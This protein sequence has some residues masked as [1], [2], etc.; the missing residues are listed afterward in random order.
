LAPENSTPS[1]NDPKEVEI[2][3]L[4]TTQQN[5]QQTPNIELNPKTNQKAE[6]VH[7]QKPTTTNRTKTK[8]T[9]YY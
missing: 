6:V 9:P 5:L 3:Q 7:T 1:K 8:Q 4:P 2:L